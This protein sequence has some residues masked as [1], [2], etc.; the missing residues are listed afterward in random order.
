M[1][2]FFLAAAGLLLILGLTA[3]P[4][5]AGAVEV[6]FAEVDITPDVNAKPVWIAGY[7]QNRRATEVHDPLYVRCLVVRD[8]D[9][10]IALAVADVVGLHYDTVQEIRQQLS[11]FSYVMLASTHNHEG[12]DTMGIWGPAFNKSGI[13]PEWMAEFHKKIVDCVRQADANLAPAKAAYGTAEDETLLRDSREPYV[14]DGVLRAVKF[15]DPQTDKVTGIV[16]QWNCHP[17]AMGGSNTAITADFPYATIDVLKK[18]YDCPVVYFSG[19]VGGLMA[20]PR[21]KRIKNA[22]GEFLGEGDFEFCRLYGEAVGQ[23]A[24]D[25]VESAEP[26][27]LSGAVVSTKTISVPIENKLYQ[28]ARMFGVLKRTV[29][30]WTGDPEE[31]GE[32]LTPKNAKGASPAG[33]TE[34][35]YI[36]LGELHIACIPGEIYPESVYGKFQDPVDPGADFPDAPLEKPI[37][38][39]LPGE[40]ILIIGLANDE[41]GYILPK[42]QWDEKKPF[43]YGREKDQYGEENSIGPDTAP[44]LYGALERRV[45]EAQQP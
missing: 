41:L 29:R 39:I 19:P 5:H 26:L 31:I 10:K 18:K 8:G 9:K 44:I 7:G 1:R 27:D 22:A 11:D 17:E 12:P 21:D 16:V 28:A 40:K 25:A 30:V 43:A 6:G 33:E 24:I 23:L 35:A 38:E 13:D 14:F 45:Q 15:L 42:R 20:P 34:V 2:A 4:A 32:L 36:R 3:A 37:V